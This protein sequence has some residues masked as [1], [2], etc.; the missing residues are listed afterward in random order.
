MFFADLPT[1]MTQQRRLA[2]SRRF[3]SQRRVYWRLAE[4]VQPAL[5]AKPIQLVQRQAGEYA[6]S[7]Q[8]R[9]VGLSKRLSLRVIAS[10]D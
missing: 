7:V 6:N 9:S 2:E 4:F 10:L 3:S 8:K 1:P 5:Q